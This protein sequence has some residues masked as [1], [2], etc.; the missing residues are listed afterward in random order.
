MKRVIDAIRK[1]LWVILLDM[2][3]VNLSYFLALIIRFFDGRKEVE[4]YA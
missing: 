3:A 2:V 4:C 1:D